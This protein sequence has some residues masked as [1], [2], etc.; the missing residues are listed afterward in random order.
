MLI[1]LPPMLGVGERQERDQ[2]YGEMSRRDRR[3]R[4]WGGVW[5]EDG[6]LMRLE[7]VRGENGIN[8][9][10]LINR[11]DPL[12]LLSPSMAGAVPRLGSDPRPQNP[13]GQEGEPPG[14]SL[15]APEMIQ[16]GI[17]GTTGPKQHHNPNPRAEP[18]DLLAEN[19]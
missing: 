17:P 13:E 1:V 5:D 3:R 4:E 12:F 15:A 9:N 2:G 7:Q 14:P 11:L 8:D 19:H 16:L 18:M 6:G 10:W